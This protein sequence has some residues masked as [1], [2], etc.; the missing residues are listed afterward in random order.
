MHYFCSLVV[1]FT[2]YLSNQS[3]CQADSLDQRISIYSDISTKLSSLSD[4]DLI[5]LLYKAKR[6]NSK[7]TGESF[8]LNIDDTR[9]FV[10]KIPLTDLE[11][12]SV[13]I[14]STSN[15]FNLPLFYQYG[16]GSAGFGV[17]RELMANIMTTNWVITRE[18][19]NFPIMYHWRM[20]SETGPIKLNTDE[21]EQNIQNWGNSLEI[22][23]R[24][25]SMIEASNHIFFFM[26]YIPYTLAQWLDNIIPI[27][28]DT[29]ANNIFSVLKTN[30]DTIISFINTHGFLHFDAN[31]ENIMTD[32]R[33][34]YLSD[35][36]L[37]LSS[38]FKLSILET[39][40]LDAH[41]Q[42]DQCLVDI[43]LFYYMAINLWGQDQWKQKLQNFLNGQPEKS[44][45]YI[46][47][48]I[49]KYGTMAYNLKGD[50]DA[51]IHCLPSLKWLDQLSS[52]TPF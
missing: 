42:Y 47:S 28:D 26:E 4:Q 25:E 13:N 46:A 35:F 52:K 18:C 39:E 48:M 14:K 43:N 51:K 32:G 41:L 3:C 34:L 24:L 33:N 21:I 20:L 29:Q 50:K 12:K 23:K 17:W 15:L 9:I 1:I 45:P 8:V 49:D 27:E 5:K 6:I 30:I 22:R 7:I 44:S 2:F 19:P 36:G 11:K 10:K 38:K 37:A 40:F 31:F 16:I